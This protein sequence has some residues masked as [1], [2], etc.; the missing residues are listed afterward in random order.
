[1][2]VRLPGAVANLVARQLS[3]ILIEFIAQ[4]DSFKV[5]HRNRTHVQILHSIRDGTKVRQK[6]PRHV[7]NATSDT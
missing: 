1:M 2:R 5:L 4:V 6:I 7:G 3:W